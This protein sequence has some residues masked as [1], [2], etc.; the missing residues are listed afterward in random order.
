MQELQESNAIELGE[1]LLG[2][3]ALK[4]EAPTLQ[5]SRKVSRA[6]R[7]VAREHELRMWQRWGEWKNKVL[8]YPL[9]V[10]GYGREARM[11]DTMIFKSLIWSQSPCTLSLG[12]YE[13]ESRRFIH[14][15]S[16][17]MRLCY[18]GVTSSCQKG[19]FR[20]KQAS[21]DL[22]PGFKVSAVLECPPP[23]NEAI[24]A[25]VARICFDCGQRKHDGNLDSPTGNYC[26]ECYEEEPQPTA[27]WAAFIH[28][29]QPP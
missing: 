9:E 1:D 26:K 18:P 20:Y 4:L 14:W 6:F 25:E 17:A 5:D 29:Y 15:R 11:I 12:K 28:H 23:S 2:K 24:L 3:I 13:R 19:C 22:P 21:L 10:R 7:D 27:T 16:A 8:L